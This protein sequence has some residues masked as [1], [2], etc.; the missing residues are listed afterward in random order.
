MRD[1]SSHARGGVCKH[2]KAKL[3]SALHTVGNFAATLVEDIRS[4]PIFSTSAPDGYCDNGSR[5]WYSKTLER[6]KSTI[7]SRVRKGV[8]AFRFI[9]KRVPITSD[10][11]R[12]DAL[13]EIHAYE[14]ILK[15]RHPNIL[16]PMADYFGDAWSRES[17]D[18][19]MCFILPHMK[20]DLLT[21]VM[22][23]GALPMPRATHFTRQ[24][25]AAVRHLHDRIGVCHMD[26]KLDNVFVD[27]D[28]SNIQ[29]GDFGLATPFEPGK[30][31][32]LAQGSPFYMAPEV[33]H[34]REEWKKK[35]WICAIEFDAR[36]A[37]Y[38]SVGVCA[39]LMSS[40]QYPYHAN[41]VSKYMADR[42]DR[43]GP[44]LS[45]SVTAPWPQ[46]YVAFIEA[47]IKYDPAQRHLSTL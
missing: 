20:A 2:Q 46:K 38:W 16:T 44:E 3:P 8:P 1:P 10:C 37:D 6:R 23:R 19:C 12:N 17:V 39:H 13:N 31:C 40:G 29:L 25:V 28:E 21:L 30:K 42:H 9:E 35:G 26:I 4:P 24:L 7:I 34:A 33:A 27:A 5:Y 45:A 18:G 41:Y 47:C 11:L 32:T 36:Q 15:N 22:E 14:K 43:S